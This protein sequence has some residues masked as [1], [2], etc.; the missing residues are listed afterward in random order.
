MANPER[1]M[2]TNSEEEGASELR[3]RKSKYH[4]DRQ[5]MDEKDLEIVAQRTERADPSIRE[6]MKKSFRCSNSKA[7]TLLFKLVPILRWL[8][9]YPIR[10][11]LLGDVCSGF[12]VGIVQLPQSMAYALLAAVPPV[13]GLYT[14]FF[15][16]LIYFIFGTSRHV[17]VGSF[18]VLSVM[19][20]TITERMAPNENFVISSMNNT[21][22]TVVI[23]MVARDMMRVKVAAMVTFLCGII[24]IMLG[25]IRFGFVVTYLSDPLVRGYTTGAAVHVLVSQLIYVLGISVPKKNGPLAL[26][27]TFIDII[28]V[29]HLTN[30]GTLVVGLIAMSTML[31]VKV[32]N[33]VFKS[34]LP[35][36]IPIELIEVIIAT[37]VGTYV[38]LS[39]KY[40][41]E[42][43]GDIPKGL[44]APVLPDFS[45]ASSLIGDA[46]ALAIVGY[47]VTISLGKIFALK[48]GYEVDS[49]QELIALGLSNVFGGFF[50]CFA[51]SCSLSR[52]LVQETTG[53]NTQLASAVSS[54]L[55]L[56]II[57]EI[58]ALFS[59]LPKAILASIVIINL[60]GMFEQVT[61]ICYFWRTNK[62]DLVVWIVTLILTVLLGMDL[63]LG[64]SIAFALLTVIFQTQL[65]KYSILGQVPDTDIYRD[66][67][68][69]DE[70][71]EIPGI[72]IFQSSA[73]IYFANAELYESA[74]RKMTGINIARLISKK[75]K[76]ITKLKQQLK[77]Q[78]N[79]DKKKAK[80]EKKLKG[81]ESGTGN[82]DVISGNFVNDN[83]ISLEMDSGQES[84]SKV[85]KNPEEYD[86]ESL[87]LPKPEVHSVI[88]DLSPVNFVDSVCIKILKIIFRD[89]KDIEVDVYLA[90]CHWSIVQQFEQGEFFGKNISKSQLFTT[91]HDAITFCL[92]KHNSSTDQPLCMNG[93]LSLAPPEEQ[94]QESSLARDTSTKF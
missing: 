72:K 26:I 42:I 12:S 94:E 22:G 82:L 53:G 16:V 38:D 74:L 15:P 34:K 91:V 21:N 6:Q 2:I 51:V 40:G 56:V 10:E 80:K 11:W 35:I 48:H 36:P 83:S 52:S 46:F 75:K 79:K 30:I 9:K 13:F 55:I 78:E 64:A 19:L 24:Q 71:K 89:F 76:R 47:G 54:A 84:S 65:P 5:V 44:I 43:V 49:N 61:D 25:M 67:K 70:A 57:L 7:Q 8:P 29:I 45:L 37:V 20:G 17:S 73:T 69:F 1:T 92:T 33:D 68:Q 60:K 23:D 4:V 63:G 59:Y 28:K 3:V 31:G 86:L 27:Y 41:I 62:I 14:S 77:K 90:G 66:I 50:Q 87:G 88:L 93:R 85:N 81:L 32:I 39:G 18:A 58:G